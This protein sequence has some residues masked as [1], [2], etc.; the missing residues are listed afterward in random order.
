MDFRPDIRS[1]TDD[2]ELRKW[3]WRKAELVDRA[4][5][6]NL[7]TTASKIELLD[8][9]TTFWIQ[10]QQ[11]NSRRNEKASNQNLTGISRR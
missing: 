2:A 6:L 11:S 1:I 9:I 7:K 8:R 3:Y 5:E 10:T 4:R